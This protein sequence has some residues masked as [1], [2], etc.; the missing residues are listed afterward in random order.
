MTDVDLEKDVVYGDAGNRPL[1][2][3]IYRPQAPNRAAVLLVHGGGWSRGSKDMLGP[4]ATALA[5][6]GFVVLAQEYRLTGEASFPANIHD[7][8]RAIRWAKENAA[9]LGFDA[10]KL[11]LEGH[12][13]GAHLVLLAAGTPD[14][15]RLA[16]P[17]GLG[18]VSQSVAAVCAIYPPTLFHAGETR[19][20]GALPARVLPGADA[21]DEAAALASP[22]EHVT[23]D[24]PPAIL[25]HGDAD[26]VVPVSASRRFEERVRAVGGKVDLHIYAGLP[27]G[28]ANHPEIRPAMMQ[29]IGG[30][31]RRWA[32][33]PE[34]FAQPAPAQPQPQPVPAE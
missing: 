14:D 23:A 15:A 20:S 24:Y 11:C 13:A 17:E 7:V 21:S 12:S 22:I 9:E 25:L 26:K 31:F 29:M 1:K 8:K 32:I 27:H 2:L 28:F 4:A 16:P 33:A 19:P 18:G 6:Q 5:E 30:F 3:D 10:D 34:V